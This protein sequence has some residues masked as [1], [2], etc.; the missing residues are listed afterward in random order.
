MSE[1]S[2]YVQVKWITYYITMLAA[3]FYTMSCKRR[4]AYEK[5]SCNTEQFSMFLIVLTIYESLQ[6]VSN[7]WFTDW[8]LI[9]QLKLWK[10][11]FFNKVS[12]IL[13]S[14][15]VPQS[16]TNKNNIPLP[17]RKSF[18]IHHEGF[19]SWRNDRSMRRKNYRKLK[20]V[21][22]N[23]WLHSSIVSFSCIGPPKWLII[24]FF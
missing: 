6:P 10:T 8:K 14:C 13:H 3:L 12:P 22:E 24:I 1:I 4:Y 18:W 20:H 5:T 15:C 11:T 21:K 19:K 2:N 16:F 17:V 9:L 23:D 7:S